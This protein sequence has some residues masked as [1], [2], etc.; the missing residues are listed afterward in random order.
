M[1]KVS[2]RKLR[3]C[4]YAAIVMSQSSPIERS[5]LGGC[6]SGELARPG[7]LIVAYVYLFA[8]DGSARAVCL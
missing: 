5:D 3:H 4:R 6:F 8:L 2:L 7:R 1:L